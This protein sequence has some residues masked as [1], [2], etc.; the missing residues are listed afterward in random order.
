[1]R[2]RDNCRE[3]GMAAMENRYLPQDVRVN[4]RLLQDVRVKQREAEERRR[5][6]EAAAAAARAPAAALAD[7]ILERGWR[8]GWP[9]LR[10][11][12]Y[13]PTTAT[14]TFLLTECS[15]CSRNCSG[16]IASC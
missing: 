2:T 13:L 16:A 10:F 1:M 7:A 9:Q 5:S 11:G 6:A 12:Q 8:V 14:R 15:V 4:R 3:I